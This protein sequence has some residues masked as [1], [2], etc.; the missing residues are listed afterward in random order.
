LICPLP[1]LAAAALG[2][3]AALG[4]GGGPAADATPTQ[5]PPSLAATATRET[6]GPLPD[7]WRGR[8]DY[9]V[10]VQSDGVADTSA[11]LAAQLAPFLEAQAA[12]A[13]LGPIRVEAGCPVRYG[14]PIRVD[15]PSVFVVS[16]FV[17][18]R[19]D[20]PLAEIAEH[21]FR[22]G[23][24]SATPVTFQWTLARAFLRDEAGLRAW[25]AQVMGLEPTRR[26]I[27]GP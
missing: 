15:S 10:C 17:K 5:A 22:P 4:C 9:R 23:S 25:L 12:A 16:I 14:Q 24:D 26:V 3:A 13:S 27:H 18:E 19:Q 1:V 8:P 20:E 11:Q 21:W 7:D 2:F 6:C